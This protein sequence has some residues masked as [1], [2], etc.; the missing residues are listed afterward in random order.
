MEIQ[1]CSVSVQIWK[2]QLFKSQKQNHHLDVAFIL[3]AQLSAVP[4]L[5]KHNS[6]FDA[7]PPNCHLPSFLFLFS[8]FCNLSQSLKT[9]PLISPFSLAL[10]ITA[11]AHD[12]SVFLTASA[13]SSF[14]FY[15]VAML[16]SLIFF[17]SFSFHLIRLPKGQYKSLE[18]VY[19]SDFINA[20]ESV[21]IVFRYWLVYSKRLSNGYSSL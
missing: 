6:F 18:W 9:S 11:E 15:V 5:W 8:L 19:I 16:S 20:N 1:V 10:K 3:T 13:L 14:L 12:V 21:P 7:W 17:S 2:S 4:L